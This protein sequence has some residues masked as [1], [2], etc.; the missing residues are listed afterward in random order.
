MW[1]FLENIH[2]H[3]TFIKVMKDVEDRVSKMKNNVIAR[4]LE[5]MK[6]K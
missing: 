5:L 2:N 3:P 1:L 4:N 6:K